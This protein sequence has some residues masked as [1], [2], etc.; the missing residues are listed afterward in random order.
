MPRE[1]SHGASDHSPTPRKTRGGE[2]NP[3]AEL[4]V[5]KPVTTAKRQDSS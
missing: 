3:R 1:E 4:Q 5:S 2:H